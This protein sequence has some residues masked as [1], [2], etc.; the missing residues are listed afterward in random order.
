MILAHP[1][2]GLGPEQVGP[3]FLAYVP[4]DIHKPLPKGWY[5]HLHNVYLQYAAERGIPAL[6]VMLWLLAKIMLDLHRSARRL[7]S[8]PVVWVLY[9]AVA[10]ETGVL[11]EGFFEYNL[12]DSEVLTMFLVAVTCGYVL[13]WSVRH[14]TVRI[15]SAQPTTYLSAAAVG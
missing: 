13:R 4:A 9:G 12:G 15:P 2:L 11:A 10:V 8:N 3:Q 14:E 5:G 6:A 7:Q 1:W